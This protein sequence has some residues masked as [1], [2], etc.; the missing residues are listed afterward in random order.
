MS[1]AADAFGEPSA[2]FYAI[3]TDG[4]SYGT[5]WEASRRRQ[6]PVD[7]AYTAITVSG[8]WCLTEGRAGS[9]HEG[10]ARGLRFQGDIPAPGA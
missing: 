5:R 9:R 10:S 2:T 7:G 3:V 1:Q 8:G 4:R 6:S